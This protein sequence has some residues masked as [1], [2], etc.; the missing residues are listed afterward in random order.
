MLKKELEQCPVGLSQSV[1]DQAVTALTSLL[2]MTY[3]LALKTQ[4]CHWNVVG[5]HFHALHALFEEQYNEYTPAI[6]EIAER[7]RQLGYFVP[8]TM[9]AYVEAS[10]LDDTALLSSSSEMLAALLADNVSI[11][12]AMRDALEPLE[13]AGVDQVTMDMFLQRIAV[14]EK[15]SWM[16]R[17]HLAA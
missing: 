4:G 12:N 7:I 5:P 3:A 8:A 10:S 6:D 9:H 13:S 16:L 14:H 15:N 1:A 17:S 11:A 2:S